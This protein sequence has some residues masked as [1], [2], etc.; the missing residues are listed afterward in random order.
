LVS[1]LEMPLKHATMEVQSP[2]QNANDLNA[3][4][5]AYR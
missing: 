5:T 3:D 1:C 2:L 4:A